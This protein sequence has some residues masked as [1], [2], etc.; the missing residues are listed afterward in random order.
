MTNIKTVRTRA[1]EKKALRLLGEQELIA[2]EDA[3]A[4]N[5]T[6]HPVIKD[7]GGVRKARWGLP[8]RGKS[9]GVRI[10]YLFVAGTT[11]YFFDIYGKSAKDDLTAVEKKTLRNTV[12]ATKK[13]RTD[14]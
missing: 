8:G 12:E 11:V 5:P 3:I 4:A 2:A 13:E 7:T 6:A 9:G 10:I 1:F 14:G